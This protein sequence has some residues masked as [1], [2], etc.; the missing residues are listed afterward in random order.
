MPWKALTIM[1]GLINSHHSECRLVDWFR[2]IAALKMSAA[3][4]DTIFLSV[5]R[6]KFLSKPAFVITFIV[7]L[8]SYS[9]SRLFYG[10][11]CS[12]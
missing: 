6:F 1:R 2:C 12:F 10:Y 3:T 11:R 5:E 8:L 7:A 9:R 4:L